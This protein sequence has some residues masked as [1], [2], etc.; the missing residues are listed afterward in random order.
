MKAVCTRTRNS[1]ASNF[2]DFMFFSGTPES[3]RAE[4]RGPV[5]NDGESERRQRSHS[6]SRKRRQSGQT[7]D[8]GNPARSYPAFGQSRARNTTVEQTVR[9]T[10]SPNNR[11][12]S[13]GGGGP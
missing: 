3:D 5:R 7:A 11:P 6:V 4:S 1:V 2:I 8:E 9:G 12:G 13:F 10:A